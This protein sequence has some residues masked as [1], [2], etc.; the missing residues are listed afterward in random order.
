M[1]SGKVPV[2]VSPPSRTRKSPASA[3]SPNP[4]TNA[5]HN[6]ADPGEDTTMKEAP[7]IIPTFTPP[8]ATLTTKEQQQLESNLPGNF[9]AIWDGQKSA[10]TEMEE[11]S[12]QTIEFTL[13]TGPSL[14]AGGTGKGKATATVSDQDELMESL[15]TAGNRPGVAF[16]KLQRRLKT[17]DDLVS[18]LPSENEAKNDLMEAEEGVL[19]MWKN[20]HSSSSWW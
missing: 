20:V 15:K 10:E 2:Q 1:E 12:N 6:T 5:P 4:P 3:A 9:K 18:R 11:T 17:R 19:D 14:D 16:A 13:P 7:P 8:N